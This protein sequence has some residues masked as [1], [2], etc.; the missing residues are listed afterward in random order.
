VG[1]PRAEPPDPGPA[2]RA[3][4]VGRALGGDQASAQGRLARD[5][6]ARPERADG[7]RGGDP[8]LPRDRHRDVRRRPAVPRA[9]RGGARSPAA[10][11]ARSLLG[12]RG[13]R[14][15]GS[16]GA[17]RGPARARRARA[18]AP[19]PAVAHRLYADVRPARSHRRHAVLR[20][21]AL[22]LPGVRRDEH[23][24]RQ[25]HR[26]P[27]APRG[28]DGRGARA[29]ATRRLQ[30]PGPGLDLRPRPRAAGRPGSR[31]ARWTARRV[32]PRPAPARGADALGRAGALARRVGR[33][34]C[35]A[36]L[37]RAE[38]GGAGPRDR[39]RPADLR[40]QHLPQY[41]QA[42]ARPVAG[43]V[44]EPLSLL[45]QG[46]AGG[47]LLL[48]DVRPALPDVAA[49]AHARG[50]LRRGGLR[51][52]LLPPPAAGRVHA[53]RTVGHP[54]PL[55]RDARALLPDP[56][57]RH[58]RVHATRAGAPGRAGRR[59]RRPRGAA[60]AGSP[61]LDLLRA[62][63]HLGRRGR[64]VVRPAGRLRPGVFGLR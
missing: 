32:R 59:A 49:P 45:F 41:L 24:L 11:A 27:R 21:P 20:P 52:P 64:R 4:R 37:G 63:R 61:G 28:E 46:A 58:L 43:R 26:P 55:A 53:D 51:Q 34:L 14:L 1:G 18:R 6:P 10:L 36:R 5:R 23:A 17:E 22:A 16:E 8:A 12:S 42:A 38:A 19:V 39:G 35:R 57:S 50:H 60:T 62:H 13:R 56:G 30:A 25:G 47:V 54:A 7:G 29:L 44:L 48:S 15:A 33:G 2:P 31:T 40:L 9:A 3:A